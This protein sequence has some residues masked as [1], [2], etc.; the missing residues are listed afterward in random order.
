MPHIGFVHFDAADVVRHPVVSE[1]IK[2]YEDGG[3]LAAD[4]IL[5]ENENDK[6]E[7]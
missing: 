6:D 7:D 3:D 4:K 2:A 5:D 1:I